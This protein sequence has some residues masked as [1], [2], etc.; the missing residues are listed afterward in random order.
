MSKMW[1]V[2][3]LKMDFG[4]M[5]GPLVGQSESQTRNAFRLASAIGKCILWWDELEKGMGSQ[6]G[7]RDGG[8]SQRVLGTALTWME[9]DA[10]KAGVFIYATANEIEQLRPELLRRFTALFFVDLPSGEDRRDILRIHIRKTG[11]DP[12]GYGNLDTLVDLTAGFTGS[13]CE[14][15][16]QDALWT[17]FDEGRDLTV[18]DLEAAAAATEPLSKTMAPQIEH[19]RRWADKARP[20]SSRQTTGKQG[21]PARLVSQ[22]KS[23]S[24]TMDM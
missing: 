9:E 18:A 5:Y 3:V 17:A 10:A 14:T 7:E 21:T 24:N 13:E 22:G 1:N 19:M 6:G 8:T 23:R 4:A 20:V 16:V 11:R 15:V 2:P 12:L